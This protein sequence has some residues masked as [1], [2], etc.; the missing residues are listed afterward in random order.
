M[1]LSEK[2]VKA[3]RAMDEL[4]FEGAL[5]ILSS[6]KARGPSGW[7]ARND[8]ALCRFALG[9]A[10]A[11][12]AELDRALEMDPGNGFL[13]INRFYVEETDKV[14]SAPAPRPETRI[15][16]TRGAGVASPLVTVIMPTYNR[17]DFTAES[18]ESVLAQT[19][20]DWELLIVNDGGDRRVE[21]VLEKYLAD[22][23]VRYV[24]AEHGGLGSAR[25]VA[26]SAGR[27]RYAAQ[28]DDDDVFYPDHLATLAGFMQANPEAKLAYTDANRAFQRK[29][30]GE[31]RTVRTKVPYSVDFDRR[32]M[33]HQS[34]VPVISVMYERE[35]AAEIGYYNEHILRS[36]DWEFF[37]RFSARYDLHHLPRVTCE[38]RERAD[39]S[40]MTRSFDVPYNY[41]RNMVGYLHGFFPLTGAR[42][43]GAGSSGDKLL[44][45]MS[46]LVRDDKDNFFAR[47]LELRKLLVEPYY[48]IFYALSKRLAEEGERDASREALRASVCVKPSELKLWFKLFNG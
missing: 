44:R 45:A 14:R 29:D 12:L 10:D 15:L 6:L 16:E 30:G 25:N 40:Q 35:R 19:M 38:Q 21:E 17:C 1:R 33:R 26:I 18:V 27:G 46:G 24:Y 22:P 28:L 41:Y 9:D 13:K 31:W 37:L 36:E 11:A 43:L 8:L 32:E 42:M 4:D 7:P 47:R 34:Y 48:A 5:E 20:D 3:L 23:R 39:R 2:H